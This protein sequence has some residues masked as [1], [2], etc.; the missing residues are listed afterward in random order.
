MSK[1]NTKRI[2]ELAVTVI[3]NL[4]FNTD[5]VYVAGMASSMLQEKYYDCTSRFTKCLPNSH[6]SFELVVEKSEISNT[7]GEGTLVSQLEMV[8]MIGSEP[9]IVSFS[10]RPTSDEYPSL[11]TLA[12]ESFNFLLFPTLKAQEEVF[13]YQH[14][15]YLSEEISLFG[16]PCDEET[17]ELYTDLRQT[18]R[19]QAKDVEVVRE[20]T[21]KLGVKGIN[22]GELIK[23]LS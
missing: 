14:A 3:K 13:G 22:T 19:R 5:D 21:E 23:L 2:C 11:D 15:F 1:E 20:L 7:L 18:L 4:G 8:V 9:T 10:F 17:A 12:V 6:T 16:K